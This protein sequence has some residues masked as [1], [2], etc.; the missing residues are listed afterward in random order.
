MVWAMFSKNFSW[1]VFC[2][3]P[4]A[5]S[6]PQGK[7]ICYTLVTKAM[8]SLSVATSNQ[9]FATLVAQTVSDILEQKE[10]SKHT[11]S[12][13]LAGGSTPLTA[14]KELIEHP[15]SYP[16]DWESTKL[17]LS[18]ER[19]VPATHPDANQSHVQPLFTS[20]KTSVFWPDTSSTHP[21]HVSDTYEQTILDQVLITNEVPRFD[22]ILLGIGPDGHTASIF[23]ESDELIHPSKRLVIPVVDAPKPPANRVSFSLRLINNAKQIIILATGEQKASVVKSVVLAEE[24]ALAYPIA[25]VN[26]SQGSVHWIVDQSAASHLPPGVLK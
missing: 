19:L 21:D 7:N 17:F 8:H 2:H 13:A 25:H 10:S 26:P 12:L 11:F 9:H 1:C 4:K 15:D 6:N 22:C 18:D 3:I 20:T 14:Y 5:E 23:P 24:D 16:I